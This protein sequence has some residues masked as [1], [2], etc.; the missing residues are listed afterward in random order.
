[1]AGKLGIGIGLGIDFAALDSDLQKV[2][3]RIEETGKRSSINAGKLA[4]DIA[5]GK[6]DPE[7]IGSMVASVGMRLSTGMAQGVRGASAAMVGFTSHIDK[8]LDKLTGS[9]VKLFRRIDSS[10]KLPTFDNAIRTA[11]GNLLDFAANGKRTLTTL[12]HA[13]RG[14]FGGS[15]ATIAKIIREVI[16]EITS[17][18]TGALKSAVADLAAEFAKLPARAAETV[19]ILDDMATSARKVQTAVVETSTAIPPRSQV[20]GVGRR[21]GFGTDFT[22]PRSEPSRR[23][24]TPNLGKAFGGA[25]SDIGAVLRPVGSALASMGVT[26]ARIGAG[27]GGLAIFMVEP[28]RKLKNFLSTIGDVGKAS[29]QKLFESQNIFVRAL[30]APIKLTTTFAKGLFHIG[31]LGVFRKQAADAGMA[32]SAIGKASGAVQSFGRDVMVALGAFGLAFKAVQFIKDGIMGASALNETVNRT[33]VV[34]GEAFGP[35]EAQANA[36]SNA[37]RVSRQSQMD[38][39]AGFGA[40]AQGAGMSEKASADLANRMTAMAANL[41]SSVNVPFEETSGK[42]RS[43]LAGQSEPLR[44]F[45]VLMTE[46]SV[47]AKAM[48]MGLGQAKG[49]IS[50]QAKMMARA[51]LVVEGLA[52]AENDLANTADSTANQFRKAGGGLTEFATRIGELLLPVL[53]PLVIAFNDAATAA[54]EFVDRNGSKMAEW[55]AMAAD[56]VRSVISIVVQLGQTV[57]T[58][59]AGL[60]STAFGRSVKGI[61]DW[62]KSVANAA[63]IVARNWKDIMEIVKLRAGAAFENVIRW[64]KVIPPNFQ[65][66]LTWLGR[67]WW[68]LLVDLGSFAKTAFTNLLTNAKNFGMALWDAIQGKGFDFKWEAIGKGFKAQTEQLPD[69]IRPDLINVEDQ[70]AEIMARIAEREKK[71]AED[72]KPKPIGGPAKPKPPGAAMEPGKESE[73]KLASAVEISSKEAYSVLAKSGVSGRTTAGAIRDGNK[74]AA[75]AAATLKRI[76]AK[77]GKQPELAVR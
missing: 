23:Q 7:Q 73:Y 64:V 20:A 37:F 58:Y 49:A 34:F 47:K 38:V 18:I 77:T 19:P 13:A 52:Y 15:L 55:A 39:A 24:P 69:L 25:V 21:I 66:M 76:E 14:A 3:A 35:V 51:Q 8:M 57:W 12:D 53:Q 72:M 65:Q 28:Y 75:D 9:A 70:V 54:I 74:I 10:M 4:G 11:E 62:V 60:F 36:M 71:R 59:V 61:W 63:G 68:N 43:A 16:N 29:Y 6:L 1:M 67:N 32:T 26:I 30:M 41:T 31:T 33:K 48:A 40:M 45:G 5:G 2:A 46:D 44:E 27:I 50:E 56:A 42:I 22:A 17:A